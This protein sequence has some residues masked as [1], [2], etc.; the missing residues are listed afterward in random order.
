MKKLMTLIMF[1][2][3]SSV[4]FA[5]DPGKIPN[6]YGFTIADNA[7]IRLGSHED[8]LLEFDTNQTNDAVLFGLPASSERFILTQ[9]ADMSTN[10]GL[11]DAGTPTLTILSADTSHFVSISHNGSNPVIESDGDP[12]DFPDGI[13]ATITGNA[14]TATALAANPTDCAAGQFATTIAANGNLTCGNL[15]TNAT[16][17]TT[18]TNAA[19]ASA[20][21]LTV[22]STLGIMDGSDTYN[23]A[24]ITIT[25][26]N[27]TGVSNVVNGVSIPNITGDPDATETGLKIGSGWDNGIE[28]ASTIKASGGLD[29]SGS[30]ING[31]NQILANGSITSA[32]TTNIGWSIVS[33]ANQACNTTCTFACVMGQEGTSKDMLACTDATADVCL[34]AGAN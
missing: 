13:L 26:A 1:L 23:G 34:C 4:A 31:A 7:Q 19:G 28:S 3:A 33:A 24:L 15:T 2:L 17:A 6:K 10:F 8:A 32:S 21:G 25:N 27:H 5:Q 11:N 16:I 14:D 18:Q 9:K 20:N 29:M 30:N 22:T 12:I